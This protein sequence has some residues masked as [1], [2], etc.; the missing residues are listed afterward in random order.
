MRSTLLLFDSFPDVGVTPTQH[1]IEDAT[2]EDSLTK[3]TSTSEEK[4]MAHYCIEK[5]FQTEVPEERSDCWSRASDSE[6]DKTLIVDDDG[7][8]EVESPLVCSPIP[9]ILPTAVSSTNS[10][11]I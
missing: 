4:S 11:A 6:D 1:T 10:E 9:S 3:N 2:S 5:V 7:G 8:L